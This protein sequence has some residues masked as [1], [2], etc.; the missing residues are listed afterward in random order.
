MPGVSR[1]RSDLTD[2][3]GTHADAVGAGDGVA[4]A[5]KE[6]GD[7]GLLRA[8]QVRARGHLRVHPQQAREVRA[9]LAPVDARHRV[10]VRRP[11]L[12]PLDRRRHSQSTAQIDTHIRWTAQ[13]KVVRFTSG[14]GPY[15]PAVP[16]LL[17]PACQGRGRRSPWRPGDPETRRPGDRRPGDPETR[18]RL[19]RVQPTYLREELRPVVLEEGGK[20][21]ELEQHR[22]LQDLI[23]SLRP[24]QQV[25]LLE[26]RLPHP[27]RR[28][29]PQPAAV[30]SPPP[31]SIDGPDRPPKLSDGPDRHLHP[32][33]GP[34]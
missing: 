27:P 7:G 33:D 21:L 12:P 20:A 28:L 4:G 24:P 26:Q 14:G 29:Q 2:W 19:Q 32:S 1:P 11:H 6:A 5:G 31:Q 22:L 30:G 25:E 10:H 34:D 9:E 23:V 18:R 16:V 8:N 13:I 15:S 17:S 3:P